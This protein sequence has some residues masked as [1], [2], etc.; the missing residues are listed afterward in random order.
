MPSWLRSSIHLTRG[1]DAIEL[2]HMISCYRVDQFLL[3]PRTI[4][5]STR[6]L[7]YA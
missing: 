4:A 2:P 7:T 3:R 1:A 5:A 6:I